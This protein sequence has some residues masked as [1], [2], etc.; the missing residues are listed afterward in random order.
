MPIRV[1]TPLHLG[2][3]FG[4]FRIALR[5]GVLGFDWPAGFAAL[6]A[7]A[8]TELNFVAALSPERRACIV[9]DPPPL[10]PPPRCQGRLGL[11]DDLMIPTEDGATLLVLR[12]FFP[13]RYWPFGGWAL[14]HGGRISPDNELEVLSSEELGDYW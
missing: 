9:E 7:A 2:P 11:V 5:A 12:A 8:N 1:V 6:E 10:R 4:G 14:Y 3:V 13:F